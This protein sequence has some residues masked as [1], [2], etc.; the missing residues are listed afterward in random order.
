MQFSDQKQF[1]AVCQTVQ[2][3]KLFFQF[4]SDC[5]YIGQP[6][7]LESIWDLTPSLKTW[8]LFR[9][10]QCWLVVTCKVVIQGEGLRNGVCIYQLLP[11]QKMWEVIKIYTSFNVLL[12]PTGWCSCTCRV[13]FH[14]FMWWTYTMYNT[15]CN[16]E[17]R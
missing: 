9:A 10:Q 17:D 15:T 3:V 13:E 6:S 12:K 16:W 1:F 4:V 8:I 11:P 5:M 14:V 2:I 7:L